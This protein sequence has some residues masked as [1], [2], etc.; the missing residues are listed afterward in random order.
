MQHT[1]MKSGF[2]VL[3][4][5]LAVVGVS[6]VVNEIF[7]LDPLMMPKLETPTRLAGTWQQGAT[8][9]DITADGTVSG[10]FEQL[11]I[12]EAQLKPNRTWVGRRLHLRTDY[13]IA[14]RL[15][16]GRRLSAPLRMEGDVLKGS[17]FI[18]PHYKANGPAQF[19]LVRN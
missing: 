16:D 14:G 3:A 10:R 18:G 2:V 11:P 8:R 19:R 1:V 13:R 15:D 6:L 5:V 4:A 12:R 17:M 9:I 7:L